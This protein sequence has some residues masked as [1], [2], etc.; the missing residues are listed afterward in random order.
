MLVEH[1]AGNIEVR[2]RRYTIQL[3][4]TFSMSISSAFRPAPCNR[5]HCLFHGPFAINTNLSL[6]LLH[7]RILL[8]L[9]PKRLA[10]TSFYVFL[11]YSTALSFKDTSYALFSTYG[12]LFTPRGEWV[13]L[14]RD[15]A[16]IRGPACIAYLGIHSPGI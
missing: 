13:C 1:L 3:N 12:Q 14:G 11:A 5:F 4:N 6:W 2:P 8:A 9:T 10:A 7:S 15:P 16:I